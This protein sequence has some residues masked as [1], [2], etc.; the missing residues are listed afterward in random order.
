ME[1]R[2]AWHVVV[3]IS[4][5][6]HSAVVLGDARFHRFRHDRERHGVSIGAQN[7]RVDVSGNESGYKPAPKFIRH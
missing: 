4:I 3:A 5:D 6:G 1:S 7:H 2:L